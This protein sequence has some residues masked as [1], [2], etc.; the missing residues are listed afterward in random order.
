MRG[1]CLLEALISLL[2]L[3]IGMLGL[4][5][6]QA[7]LW[8]AAGELHSNRQAYLLASNTLEKALYRQATGAADEAAGAQ[9]T[10][11]LTPATEYLALVTVTAQQP[12]LHADVVVTW[13]GRSGPRRLQLK[14]AA[15]GNLAVADTRWLLSP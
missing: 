7:G 14:T 13:N 6:L 8:S 9:S 10:E 1:F 2:V 12:I 15:R 11:L 4:A 3:S 5:R